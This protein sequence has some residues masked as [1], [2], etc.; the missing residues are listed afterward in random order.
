MPLG[1]VAQDRLYARHRKRSLETDE[2]SLLAQLSCALPATAILGR[3]D[4]TRARHSTGHSAE[5][6]TGGSQCPVLLLPPQLK[7]FQKAP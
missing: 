6:T 5:G 2:D 1:G 7:E 3:I 4:G